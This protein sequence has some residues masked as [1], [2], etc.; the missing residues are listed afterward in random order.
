GGGV[1]EYKKVTAGKHPALEFRPRVGRPFLY[2]TLAH[3][4]IFPASE[5]QDRG[6]HLFPGERVSTQE[7]QVLT[8]K[9]QEVGPGFRRGK[10]P[11]QRSIALHHLKQKLIRKSARLP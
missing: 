9:R 2:I 4:G 11:R 3:H 6:A 10:L 8:K 5:S 7:L 1:V